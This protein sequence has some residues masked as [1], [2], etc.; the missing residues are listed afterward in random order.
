MGEV[1][2]CWGLRTAEGTGRQTNCNSCPRPHP[3]HHLPV[4]GEQRLGGGAQ[5]SE[6]LGQDAELNTGMA[7][8]GHSGNSRTHGVGRLF[9]QHRISFLCS[10]PL[11]MTFV[12]SDPCVGYSPMSLFFFLSFLSNSDVRV[13]PIS[14]PGLRINN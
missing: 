5:V 2:G 12:S 1:W 8:P 13:E 14:L 11:L 6:N 10:P 9:G 3:V 4:G 7:G